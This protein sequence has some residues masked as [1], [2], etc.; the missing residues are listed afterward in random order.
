M[1][2]DILID[3]DGTITNTKEVER[4]A[5]EILFKKYN[6]SYNENT[7]KEYSEINENLWL[8]FEKGNITKEKLRKKRF[9]ILFERM[10][11]CVDINS[12]SNEY[13]EIYSKTPI[14]FDNAIE[15]IRYLSDKYTLYIISNGSTDVQ[16]YKLDKMNITHLFKN[17]FL[18]EE[19]G[20]AKPDIRFFKYVYNKIVQKDKDKILVVGDSI[21]ADISGGKQFGFDTC[22]VGDGNS[23]AD[24]NISTLY[25]IKEIL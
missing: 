10:K 21:S 8:E 3:I 25:K 12:I 15:T 23:P 11:I 1:Y 9:E 2:T 7:V 24:F 22:Y 19:I 20:Y 18:S 6:I 5:L 13:F 4:Y 17:I 14:P 16:Y